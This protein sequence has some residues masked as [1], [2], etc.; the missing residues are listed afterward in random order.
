VQKNAPGKSLIEKICQHLNVDEK[1]Y[2]GLLYV[3]LKTG[4]KVWACDEYSKQICSEFVIE[5]VGE[6]LD[7]VLSIS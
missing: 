3:D 1:E 7:I 4:L 5:F 2:F 6:I